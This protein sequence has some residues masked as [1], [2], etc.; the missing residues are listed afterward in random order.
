VHFPFGQG[1]EFSGRNV[2]GE[3]AELDALDFFDQEA[4][5][6]EH[7]ADLAIAAFDESDCVPGI[8]HVLEQAD[9]SGRELDAPIVVGRDGDAV[10]EFLDS[11]IVGL[12]ADFDVIGFGD[13]GAGFREFL[14]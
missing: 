7:A 11:L 6:E 2:E 5:G 1:T 9:F 4:Y 3:G 10:A 13:V 14:G 8:F 12:A